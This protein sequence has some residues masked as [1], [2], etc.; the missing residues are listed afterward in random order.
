[1]PIV[2]FTPMIL[3]VIMGDKLTQE[4]ERTQTHTGMREMFCAAQLTSCLSGSSF[5]QTQ[6]KLPMPLASRK[7]SW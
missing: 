4:L 2:D 6:N 7:H 1:M 5:I 3:T